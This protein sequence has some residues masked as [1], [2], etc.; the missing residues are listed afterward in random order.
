MGPHEY[1]KMAGRILLTSG[2]VARPRNEIGWSELIEANR[3][4]STAVTISSRELANHTL[5]QSEYAQWKQQ[6]E[7]RKK[8]SKNRRL[9][10]SIEDYRGVNGNPM[11][12]EGFMRKDDP[13]GTKFAERD[14][15]EQVGLRLKINPPLDTEALE[16]FRKCWEQQMNGLSGQVYPL[17]SEQPE[18]IEM[19]DTT[20]T[21][22]EVI[23]LYQPDITV[24][25]DR[26]IPRPIISQ[27]HLR[28]KLNYDDPEHRRAVMYWREI[29]DRAPAGLGPSDESVW[30]DLHLAYDLMGAKSKSYPTYMHYVVQRYTD[31]KKQQIYDAVDGRGPEG[32]RTKMGEAMI[33]QSKSKQY[34]YDREE[35]QSV[36]NLPV[37]NEGEQRGQ[38]IEREREKSEVAT[39]KRLS[40][41]AIGIGRRP[42][43]VRCSTAYAS[44]QYQEHPDGKG[45]STIV[46]KRCS[47]HQVSLQ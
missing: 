32:S 6:E 4:R 39:E 15:E 45:Q 11:Y 37:G 36:R 9:G 44:V 18:F 27:T 1:G 8:S 7:E 47:G 34:E 41:N 28:V 26:Y 2:W 38:A 24:S 42:V 30:V 21:A 5:I 33:K 20:K 46:D 23:D 16:D 10:F 22:G 31:F 13:I 35:G 14:P 12:Y 43:D 3:P 29:T 25:S 19:T 17:I 40:G